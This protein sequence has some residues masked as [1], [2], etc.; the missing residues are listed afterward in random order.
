MKIFDRMRTRIGGRKVSNGNVCIWRDSVAH[1]EG[2]WG[3]WYL[4]IVRIWSR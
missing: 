2:L 3:P 1:S 4:W